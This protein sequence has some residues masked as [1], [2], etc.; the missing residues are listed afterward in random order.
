MEKLW[1]I[2][3]AEEVEMKEVRTF[4]MDLFD[5]RKSVC[6]STSTNC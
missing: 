5:I 2:R 6:S 4:E 1:Y 3:K